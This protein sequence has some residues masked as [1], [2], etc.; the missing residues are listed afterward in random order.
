MMRKLKFVHL[1]LIISSLNILGQIPATRLLSDEELLEIFSANTDSSV[2]K[3]SFISHFKDKMGERFF[4]DHRNFH[5]RFDEYKRLYKDRELKHYQRANEHIKLFNAETEWKLPFKSKS[6]A[7]ITPYQL[8]HLARQHKMLDIAFMYYYENENYFYLN[9]FIDQV[10]SLNDKYSRLEVETGGNDVFEYFRAGY[11]VFNWL[12]V[13]NMFLAS[14]NYSTEHQLTLIKTFLMHGANLFESTKKFNSGNHHTK[15]LMSLAMI[16]ILF[17][18]FDTGK[19]WFH[20]S[21]NMLTRHLNEEINPD[22]FQFERSVHY[23]KGDIDNYF[24]IFMLADLNEIVL[25]DNYTEKFRSMFKSLA[26]LAQPDGTLPVLQDDTDEPW[27]EFNTIGSVMLL[28]AL[29]FNDQLYKYFAE[30]TVSES[31]YWFIKPELYSYLK[32]LKPTVP[33]YESTSLVNTGYYVM[34]NG[35]SSRSDYMVIN[36]GKS[37]RKPD[38]QHADMLGIAAYSNG[39]CVLP[40]YQVRYFLDDYRFFKSSFVKNVALVDSIPQASLWKANKGGSGFGKWMDLPDPVTRFWKTDKNYDVFIG[41]HNAYENIGVEY[42]RKVIFIKDGFWIVKDSFKSESPHNYQQIWQGHYSIELNNIHLRS[43][44][45]NG[46]GL[47]IVQ[48]NNSIINIDQDDFRGKGTS[49]FNT[50]SKDEHDFIT[51]LFP[52]A[53]FDERMIIDR[54]MSDLKVGEWII[55]LAEKNKD[56]IHLQSDKRRITFSCGKIQTE[57]GEI[58]FSD[59]TDLLITRHNDYFEIANI[60]DKTVAVICSMPLE[61]EYGRIIDLNEFKFSCGKIIKLRVIDY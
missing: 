9:Y 52:F 14:D 6:G 43:T 29:I 27:G 61:D 34:R 36:A 12:F 23:H 56:R 50:A 55:T 37:D 48:M 31:Y 5:E 60:D 25:P 2:S 58:L 20:H 7:L 1:L 38:H 18:E 17:P 30:N 4:F 47:D 44:F 33:D 26:L 3:N 49:V 46:S 8:R 16:S 28:G 24:Y 40:N 39:N 51:L 10:K 53:H 11:R 54:H 21:I 59:K 13:H 42:K 45:Q 22:G 19:K 32:N 35:W 57:T 15:G 41:S